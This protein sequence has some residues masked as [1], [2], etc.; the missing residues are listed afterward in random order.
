MT[1]RLERQP[2]DMYSGA[3]FTTKHSGTVLVREYKNKDKVL[4]TFVESGHTVWRSADSIRKGI[5]KDPFSPTVAGKGYMGVGDYN[6]HSGITRKLNPYGVWRQILN[7]CYNKEN[8]LFKWYGAKGVYVEDI[9]H[10]YQN[11]A[12]WYLDN[13]P[14]SGGKYQIDKDIIGGA[15]YLKYSPETCIFVTPRTNCVEA[16][17]KTCTLL[18]PEGIEVIVSNI[19]DFCRQNGLQQPLLSK[20]LNGHRLHHRGWKFLRW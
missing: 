17:A 13:Y 20:V 10:N 11:F 16:N 1:T 19:T 8:T 15:E 18:S 5:V 14:K 3:I 12:K 9:W 7:R 2:N 4:I 6:R